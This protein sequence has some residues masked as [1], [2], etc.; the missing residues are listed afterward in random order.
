[1]AHERQSLREA[2]V[3]QLM[4]PSN[5]RTAAGAR[6]FETRQAPIKTAQL[7]AI[8]VYVDSESVSEDS[9]KS[10]PRELKRVAIIAVEGWVWA[11]DSVDDSLD[12]LALEIETA[13]DIDLN[14]GETAFDSVLQSSDFGIKLDGERPMGAV[15]LEYKV[16]YHTDLR[17]A[18]AADD[19]ATADVQ[20]SLAGDQAALDQAHDS[21]EDIHE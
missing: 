5:N 10:A 21:I 7:P 3:L 18:E 19:F 12:D 6:I 20:Y 4:G 2:I 16:T 11:S 9:D 17:V 14:F 1:M 8:S 13:M 15:R